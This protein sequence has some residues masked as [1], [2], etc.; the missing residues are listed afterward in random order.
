MT[1]PQQAAVALHA[2][3]RI[4]LDVIQFCEQAALKVPF[5]EARKYSRANQRIMEKD[6]P[7]LLA[8]FKEK[9]AAG[10]GDVEERF[11]ERLK[12]VEQKVRAN[13][14]KEVEYLRRLKLRQAYLER[15]LSPT[16]G[17]KMEVEWM[18]LRLQR[19][20]IEYKLDQGCIEEAQRLVDQLKMHDWVDI[21]PFQERIKIIQ[22]LNNQQF[23]SA[24]QW[25]SEYRQS[26]KKQKSLL[27]FML[28]RQEMIE[29]ATSR[30]EEAIAYGRKHLSPWLE[31]DDGNDLWEMAESAMNQII[32]LDQVI[33][34]ESHSKT[35]DLFKSEFNAMYSINDPTLLEIIIRAGLCLIKTPSCGDPLSYNIN[36]PAC[37]PELSQLA[38]HL[39]MAHHDTSILVCRITGELMDQ[40]NPP[41]A[42]PNGHVYSEKGLKKCSGGEG[43]VM[44]KCPCTGAEYPWDQVRKVFIT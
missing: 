36:C 26:L 10:D 21:E 43:A 23:T 6:L 8:A 44:A 4:P 27:E 3:D 34:N 16:E 5:E 14:E 9:Q 1:V 32:F 40:D 39:P 37:Q 2:P 25:C 42:L 7:A 29:M 30:P 41:M 19:M 18:E 22:D 15:L 11:R 17:P 35:V 31:S 13:R 20:V 24:L 38:R 33:L 28:R 12:Q